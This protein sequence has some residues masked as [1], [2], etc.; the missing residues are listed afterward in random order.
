MI[1][2]CGI[3]KNKCIKLALLAVLTGAA[4]I[5][6]ADLTGR[7][8][9][10]IAQKTQKNVQYG[11]HIV[12]AKSGQTAY[13]YNANRALMPA[14]N[15]KVVT[16]AAAVKYLG[17]DF[18]YVT[19][20][21]LMG[22]TLVVTGSGDPLLGDEKTELKYG[23]TRG[24]EFQKVVECLKEAGIKEIEDIIVDGTIFDDQRVHANWPAEQLNRWYAAEVSG[25]NYNGNCLGMT[26]KNAGGRIN[27]SIVPQTGYVTWDN[28][29][30]GISSGSEAVGAYRTPTANKL[31]LKGKCR[32]EQ[33]PFDVAI[34]RPAAFFGYILGE[35]LG[36]AGIAAKGQ[37]V[38]RGLAQ[39]EKIKEVTAFRTSLADCICRCNKDSFGLAAEALLKTRG[40]KVAG[41]GSWERGREA[42]SR[43][44][45]GLGVAEAEFYVDDGSGLSRENKLSAKAITA[46]LTDVYRSGNWEMYRDSLAIGGADG[47]IARYFGEARYKGRIRGKT[48]YIAAVKSFSGVCA[49]KKGDFIFSI[50]TNN[51]AGSTRE[52]INDIAEAIVDEGDK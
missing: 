9:A 14:S 44:L 30:R 19:R 24:W 51:A 1:R 20:V 23:R 38:G 25:I 27:V 34:E 47:T 43:Y 22:K 31:I 40:A 17:A 26:V 2:N 12:D 18:E 32:K 39:D 7:V 49:T 33:G 15:M 10:I 16:T 29:I 48:G 41:E 36:E 37:L 46:V 11:I 35:R 50:L 28:Q 52:A 5:A 13:S 45:A 6:R 3:M 8:N 21:G 4:G 42:I